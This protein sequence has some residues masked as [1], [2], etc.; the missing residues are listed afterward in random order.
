VAPRDDVSD[1]VV[2]MDTTVRRADAVAAMALRV[3]H[4]VPTKAR[5]P[6]P[7]VRHRE[8]PTMIGPVPIKRQ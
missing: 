2:P 1:V 6:V 8:P 5:L 3:L 4:Q 7:T